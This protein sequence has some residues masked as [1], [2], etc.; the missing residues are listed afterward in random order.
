MY[1]GIYTNKL[2]V[3]NEYLEMIGE[4]I[5]RR[6][7][8]RLLRREKLRKRYGPIPLKIPFYEYIDR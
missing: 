2:N 1:R 4:V 3:D 5:L 7:E 6:R 8:E